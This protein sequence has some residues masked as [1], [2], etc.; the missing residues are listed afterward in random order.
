MV[1]IDDD[2]LRNTNTDMTDLTSGSSFDKLFYDEQRDSQEHPVPNIGE[3]CYLVNGQVRRWEGDSTEVKS[4][5]CKGFNGDQI[6]IGRLGMLSEREAMRAL[7][8]AYDAFDHG[9]GKWPNMTTEERI[10]AVEKLRDGLWSKRDELVELVMWEVSKSKKDARTEVDRSI[11][12]INSQIE[13]LRKI[14]KQCADV[15]HSSKI[16]AQVRRTPIGVTLCVAPSTYPLNETFSILIPALL[17]GNTVVL[18]LPRTGSLIHMPILE[19]YARSFPN[20]AINII[21][22][23]GGTLL[24]PIMKSGKI[25]LLAYVGAA[26]GVKKIICEHSDPTFLRRALALDAKNAAIIL[27]D[28]DLETTVEGCVTGAIS[29]NGQR[30]TTLGIMFVHRSLADKFVKSFSEKVDRLKIGLPWDEEAKITP[31]LNMSQIENL[32][33]L[34]R[35]AESKGAKVVNTGRGN[36]SDRTFFSPTVL[37]PVNKDMKIYMSEQMGP[38]TPIVPFDDLSQVYEFFNTTTK[39]LQCSV[40]SENITD[41]SSLLDYLSMNVGRINLNSQ[42]KRGPDVLPFSSRKTS[43]MGTL[44]GEYALKLMSN[45]SVLAAAQTPNSRN[46]DIFNQFISSCKSHVFRSEL[47]SVG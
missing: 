3:S 23:A 41:H 22:G 16:I 7:D 43:G 35:D 31:L 24:P 20:G 21:T 28:A 18:K 39:G 42:C 14:S 2:D 13:T 4:S 10:S 11:K 47:G 29:F 40:F 38:V 12:F 5:I 6:T 27:Q 8:A 32:K 9:R 36:Q 25:D 17:M 30:C 26:E 33:G 15:F 45:E 44:S 19:S 34:V 1:S 46:M 37:Y